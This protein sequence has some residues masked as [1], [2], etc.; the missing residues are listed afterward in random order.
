MMTI[1]SQQ[2]DYI[3]IVCRVQLDYN[4]TFP[5]ARDNVI[6]RLFDK[7]LIGGGVEGWQS[8]NGNYRAVIL[9]VKQVD[10]TLLIRELQ[11]AR[12]K[13]GDI[14]QL[15]NNASDGSYNEDILNVAIAAQDDLN[16]ALRTITKDVSDA[17]N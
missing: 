5:T 13:F 6:D 11:A 1:T 10:V 9:D 8:G 3:D 14:E 12:A 15:C 17:D 16:V 7:Q 4:P 2:T